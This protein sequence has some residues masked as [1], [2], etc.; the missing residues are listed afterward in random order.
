MDWSPPPPLSTLSHESGVRHYST[1]LQSLVC[2]KL[3]AALVVELQYSSPQESSG[4]TPSRSRE[5][6]GGNLVLF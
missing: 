4:E 1:V 2:V 5:P 6:G 3:A